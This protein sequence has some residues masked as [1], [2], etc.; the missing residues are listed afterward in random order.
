MANELTMFQQG[1]VP[2][3]VAKFLEEEKNIV[4]RVTSKARFGRSA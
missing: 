1:K 4:D 2:A 3:H